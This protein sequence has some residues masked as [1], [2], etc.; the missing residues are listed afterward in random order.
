MGSGAVAPMSSPATPRSS[1]PTCETAGLGAGTAS[2][3]T[4]ET[5]AATGAAAAG[6][7]GAS[8]P[9]SF[10]RTDPSWSADTSTSRALDPSLG[11]TMLRDSMR[12]IK[13][14][15]L[16]KPTR[17][18]RCSIDVD[19]NWLDTTSSTACNNTSRSS[20]MSASTFFV[21]P[22]AATSSRYSGSA[23]FLTWS[24]TAWISSSDTHAPCTR[25]AFAAPMGRNSPSP[26]PISFSAP[27]WSRMTRESVIDDTANARREG[28]LA[29]ISPVTTSTDGR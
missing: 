24:T 23:C 29:L 13:R 14:P 18:L 1:Y 17:N 2:L 12:S 5:A 27:C 7:T 26:W 21:F 16:A 25:I 3:A 4:A 10:A 28:T 20:P 22:T 8:S 19:P 11:P 15:A 6:A 9:R